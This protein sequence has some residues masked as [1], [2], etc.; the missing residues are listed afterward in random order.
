[1]RS[2]RVGDGGFCPLSCVLA[3]FIDLLFDFRFSFPFFF[4]MNLRAIVFSLSSVLQVF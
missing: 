3:Q 2:G 1:V 4:F